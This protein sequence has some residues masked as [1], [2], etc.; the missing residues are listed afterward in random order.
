MSC[1][2][3]FDAV[4]YAYPDGTTALREVSLRIHRGESVG[5]IGPNG[6]GK[7][8][9][10]HLANGLLQPRH[11]T[12]RVLETSTADRAALPTIRQK[13]GLVF[14][15]PDDQLFCTTVADDVAFGPLNMDLEP[16]RIQQRVREALET[17]GIDE[18]LWTKPPHHLSGGQ[19]RAV[20]IAGVLAMHPD[21]LLLDEPANNLDHRGRRALVSLLKRLDV[22]FVLA[23]HD[24]E[25]IRETCDRVVLMDAGEIIDDRPTDAILADTGV[26]AAHGMEPPHSIS[27]HHDDAPPSTDPA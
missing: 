22:T 1:A 27:H 2:L 18:S 4:T 23:S 19:K 10:F 12:V 24:L 3:H 6:A 21:V 20:A 11:G 25:L 26:L 14:Q 15:Y 5:L 9:L 13:V 7:T 17:V 8:T 16:G